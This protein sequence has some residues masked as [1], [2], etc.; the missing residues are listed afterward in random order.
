MGRREK[1]GPTHRTIVQLCGNIAVA[2]QPAPFRKYNTSVTTQEERYPVVHDKQHRHYPPGLRVTCCKVAPYEYYPVRKVLLLYWHPH[3]T[4]WYPTTKMR[5]QL[6]I[7]EMIRFRTRLDEMVT[8]PTT[9]FGTDSSASA[10]EKPSFHDPSKGAAVSYATCGTTDTTYEPCVVQDQQQLFK[11][12]QRTQENDS[13]C[14]TEKEEP[15]RSIAQH[16]SN[17]ALCT[18]QPPHMLPSSLDRSLSAH[19]PSPPSNRP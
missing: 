18:G 5:C 7:N 16:G 17:S 13:T 4:Y 14:R 3:D 10:V 8:R 15:F 11:S 19:P 6:N 9:L 12:P 2:F 1:D